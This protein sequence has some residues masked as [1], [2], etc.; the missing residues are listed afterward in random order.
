MARST[1]SLGGGIRVGYP[2]PTRPAATRVMQANR[3]RDTRPEQRLRAA[4]HRRGLR[5]RKNMLIDTDQ[6]RIRVDIAFTRQRLAVFVDG[7]FW[8]TCPDH[9]STPRANAS[10]WHAKLERNRTR[11][12]AVN[13]ALRQSGWRVARI[14]EH[15]DP[16]EAAVVIDGFVRGD[17]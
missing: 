8:H 1:I 9:G 12:V 17:G 4:L 13:D 2:A 3:R 16:T 6:R 15:Q 11:D 14:W 5:F 7:C 10:Y